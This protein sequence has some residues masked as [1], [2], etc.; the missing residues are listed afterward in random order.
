MNKYIKSKLI[1]DRIGYTKIYLKTGWTFLFVKDVQDLI[2]KHSK[3]NR[4][5]DMNTFK[6]TDDNVLEIYYDIE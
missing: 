2:R 3:H 1:E 5:E 4:V 6:I